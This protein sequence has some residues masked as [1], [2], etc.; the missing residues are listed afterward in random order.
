MTSAPQRSLT[1]VIAK[2]SI[3][4]SIAATTRRLRSS[5]LV[6]PPVVT[7]VIEPTRSSGSPDRTKN[8][9][10]TNI[11]SPR[12]KRFRVSLTARAPNPAVAAISSIRRISAVTRK[13]FPLTM[14]AAP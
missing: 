10:M 7:T 2:R 5:A 1:S 11:K 13:T 14:Q 9:W 6:S 4:G 3:S 8:S 12:I